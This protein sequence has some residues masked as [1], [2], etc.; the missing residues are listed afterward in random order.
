MLL[1]SQIFFVRTWTFL[2]G[3]ACRHAVRTIS[4]QIQSEWIESGV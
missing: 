3:S 1:L 2:P 4:S